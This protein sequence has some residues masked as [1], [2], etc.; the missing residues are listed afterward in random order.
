M[1]TKTRLI[2]VLTLFLMVVLGSACAANL[3][4]KPTGKWD[5][6]FGGPTLEFKSDNTILVLQKE[7]GGQEKTMET[8]TYKVLDGETIEIA[9]ATNPNKPE[10]VKIKFND[11]GGI[12]MT[13]AN[14]SQRVYVP[15]RVVLR[16]RRCGRQLG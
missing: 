4:R 15:A 9:W 5:S 6:Y 7:S 11:K 10:R 3:K 1:V 14:G 8:G 13:L 2:R 16:A 12:V